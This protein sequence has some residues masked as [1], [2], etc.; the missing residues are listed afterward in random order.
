MNLT[1]YTLA[2]TP[3]EA[4]LNLTENTTSDQYL[5]TTSKR[6]AIEKLNSRLFTN[7]TLGIKLYALSVICEEVK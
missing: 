6:E 5:L 4:T 7:E 1:Y 3:Q 2:R